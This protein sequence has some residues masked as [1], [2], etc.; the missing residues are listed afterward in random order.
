[1]KRGILLAIVVAL[2]F[3]AISL[4]QYKITGTVE[5]NTDSEDTLVVKGLLRT[6]AVEAESTNVISISDTL[7][8]T[9]GGADTL[10]I[11]EKGLSAKE[12]G[13]ILGSASAGFTVFADS[14]KNRVLF[15][16]SGSDVFGTA[17]TEDTIEVIGLTASD[18]V[19][20]SGKDTGGILTAETLVDTII[21]TSSVSES[22]T[23][24]FWLVM[25]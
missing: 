19:W 17:K 7:L 18:K 11:T 16:F 4:A 25:R 9:T 14:V 8:I 10:R 6:D 22:S 3:G 20:I 1:M 15:E 5:L 12:G 24:Y 2:L 21:V 23:N 13:R